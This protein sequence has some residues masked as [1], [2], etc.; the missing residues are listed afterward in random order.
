MEHNN[1]TNILLPMIR[2]TLPEIIAQDI[3]GTQPMSVDVA[4]VFNIKPKYLEKILVVDQTVDKLPAPPAGHLTVDVDWEVSQWIQ[5]QPIHMWKF[6]DVPAYSGAR[7]R[8]TVSE[9]LYTWMTLRWS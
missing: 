2:K 5:Q 6:G 8:F 1:W 3:A 4:Q 9:Q 7:D